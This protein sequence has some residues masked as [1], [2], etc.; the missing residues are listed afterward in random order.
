M[1]KTKNKEMAYR[2]LYHLCLSA[3][4]MGLSVVLTGFAAFYIPL[5]GMPS[6]RFGIGGLPILLSSLVSGPIWGLLVGGGADLIGA[7]L[8][9]TGPYFWG[10]TLDAALLGILPWIVDRILHGKAKGELTWLVLLNAGGLVAALSYLLSQSAYTNGRPDFQYNLELTP[11]LKAG[12]SFA[13][14]GLCLASCLILWILARI[15]GGER[16]SGREKPKSEEFQS[17]LVWVNPDATKR[18]EGYSFLDLSCVYFTSGLAV[19]AFLLPYWN[20][21]TFG[22]PY[23]YGIFN[24]LV[25]LWIEAPVK[26]LLYWLVLNGLMR[27]KVIERKEG[28]NLTYR[29]AVANLGRSPTAQ[30]SSK[31][32]HSD[33]E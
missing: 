31:E 18:R 2:L 13:L 3:I 4:L 28:R 8:F 1:K 30:S 14:V 27:A 16:L 20:S 19:T 12:L 10:Y 7:T 15:V 11:G 5:G 25:F 23:F 21:L 6:L 22:L 9:P 29:A 33:F 26:V 24:N 17:K 32:T